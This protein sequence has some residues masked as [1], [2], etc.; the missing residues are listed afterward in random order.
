VMSMSVCSFICLSVHSHISE[1]M[2]KRQYISTYSSYVCAFL[3]FLLLVRVHC[4]VRL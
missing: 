1:N 2:A 3:D 4:V